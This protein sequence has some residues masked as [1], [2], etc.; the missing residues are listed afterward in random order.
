[1][2]KRE[3]LKKHKILL[4]TSACNLPCDDVLETDER[5]IEDKE[6]IIRIKV[7]AEVQIVELFVSANVH[8]ELGRCDM[9]KRKQIDKFWESVKPQIISQEI[10][11]NGILVRVGGGNEYQDAI[12]KQEALLSSLEDK[13]PDSSIILNARFFGMIPVTADYDRKIKIKRVLGDDFILMTP[14]DFLKYAGYIN[15][16]DTIHNS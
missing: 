12:A 4:D 8:F 13:S 2:K 7:L 10:G 9:A 3:T 5:R 16:G 14:S 6:A 15:L 1:M 11:F